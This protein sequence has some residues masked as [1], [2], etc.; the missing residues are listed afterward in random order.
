LEHAGF[1]VGLLDPIEIL[2]PQRNADDLAEKLATV[3]GVDTVVAPDRPGWRRGGTALVDVF[4][5]GATSTPGG[6]RTVT[7]VRRAVGRLAPGASVAGDGAQEADIVHAYYARFPLVVAIVA[8]ISLVALARAWRSVVLA[9][10]AVALN[11]VSIA[12]AYGA[13]VFVWQDG[14]G[15]RALWGIPATGVVVD[16]V[17]LLV[18]AFL[19]GL[20]MD[21][22]VF[23]VSRIKEAHDS[24]LSTDDAVVEGLGR[25]GRL[26][27]A[28]AAILFLAFAALAAGPSVP[29]KVFATAMAIGVVLDATIIRALLVPA[30]VSLLGPANWWTPRTRRQPLTP[31]TSSITVDPLAVPAKR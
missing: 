6:D 2:T 23:I 9:V 24:G 27:T 25:T 20:S 28:A 19:F 7:A 31:A 1:P 4:P 3:S 5:T 30:L 29:V 8:L 22:E 18:F 16:F 26:V 11:V 17:P 10:K 14:Y 12:A 13:T 15:S 21:Y